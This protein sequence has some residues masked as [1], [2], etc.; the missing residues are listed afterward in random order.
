MSVPTA[1]LKEELKKII[2]G[3]VTRTVSND[4]TELLIGGIKLLM[5]SPFISVEDTDTFVAFIQ[6]ADVPQTKIAKGKYDSELGGIHKAQF[7]DL[8]L[9]QEQQVWEP[10]ISTSILPSISGL[11]GAPAPAPAPLGGRKRKTRA[12]KNKRQTRRR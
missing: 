9:P 4:K 2:R 11:F 1:E 12:R 10:L 5:D 8:Q 7:K 6:L 3:E